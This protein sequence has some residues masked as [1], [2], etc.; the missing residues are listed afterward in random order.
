MAEPPPDQVSCPAGVRRRV[1][2]VR[3]AEGAKAR[4]MFEAD[5]DLRALQPGGP[6]LGAEMFRRFLHWAR[7]PAPPPTG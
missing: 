1:T 2:K 7:R 6:P 5:A 4:Q 3:Q